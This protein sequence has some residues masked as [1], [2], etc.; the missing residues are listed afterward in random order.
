MTCSLCCHPCPI[1]GLGT[2]RVV[3]RLSSRLLQTGSLCRHPLPQPPGLLQVPQAAHIARWGATQPPGDLPSS[4]APPGDRHEAP[5]LGDTDLQVSYPQSFSLSLDGKIPPSLQ[6]SL[7]SPTRIPS[8]TPGEV[9]ALRKRNPNTKCP[10]DATS[11]PVTKH[12]PPQR[13]GSWD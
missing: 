4:T 2:G 5:C 7:P 10:S 11:S 12:K 6:L 13:Q 9:P 3:P 8:L 1:Q